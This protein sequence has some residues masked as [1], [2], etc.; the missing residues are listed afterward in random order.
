MDR[1]LLLRAVVGTIAASIAWL[2]MRG[3]KTLADWARRLA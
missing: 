2:L 3:G 1:E